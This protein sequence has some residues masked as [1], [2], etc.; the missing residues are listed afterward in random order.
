[1]PGKGQEV[2]LD[3]RVKPLVWHYLLQMDNEVAKKVVESV[4]HELAQFKY[5]EQH[6]NISN[7]I[8]GIVKKSWTPLRR[9]FG[10]HGMVVVVVVP[11]FVTN[12]IGLKAFFEDLR[13]EIDSRF[14]GLAAKKS[15]YSFVVLLCPHKLF[16]ACAGDAP[17]LIDKTGFHVNIVKAIV[18]IDSKTL[19]ITGE[20]S[21]PL[22]HKRE[23]EAVL[24]AASR[25]L[26]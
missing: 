17:E 13:K 21:Q 19:K 12:R 8:A 24:A 22:F 5:A 3:K 9:V 4:A 6:N 2:L 26:H 18:L 11:E 1:M 14:V 20:Y 15:S 23:Y 7:S 16:K 10:G 25:A